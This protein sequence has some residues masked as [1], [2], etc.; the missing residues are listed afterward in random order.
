MEEQKIY[1][2]CIL[3]RIQKRYYPNGNITAHVIG[4]TGEDNQGLDGIENNGKYLKGMSGKILSEVDAH[5]RQM[6]N[7][8]NNVLIPGWVKC[9]LTIDETIQYFATEALQKA[10]DD[11]KVTK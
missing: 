4:F 3:M 10:I 5:G 7:Y 2:A 11:N 8:Q 9:V 1:M 6:P